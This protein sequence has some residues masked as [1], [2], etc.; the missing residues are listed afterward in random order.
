MGRA[1]GKSRTRKRFH[2]LFFSLQQREGCYGDEA[3][4]CEA[5]SFAVNFK[6]GMG[7]LWM[8]CGADENN[9]YCLERMWSPHE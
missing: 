3:I 6:A 4:C 1:P 2:K 9:K 8:H 7:A 5:N